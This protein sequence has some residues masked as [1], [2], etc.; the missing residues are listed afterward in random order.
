MIKNIATAITL[1]S[2][3]FSAFSLSFSDSKHL[4]ERTGFGVM[5][6]DEYEMVRGYSRN[7]AI[8]LLI[9]KSSDFSKSYS[10][11]IGWMDSK[12]LSYLFVEDEFKEGA[13]SYIECINLKSKL[14]L[15]YEIIN[16]SN[17]FLE[18]MTTFWHGHFVTSLDE[19]ND[20]DLKPKEM[21]KHLL[22]YRE[23]SLGNFRDFTLQM[24]SSWVMM[25][26]LG[27]SDNLVGANNNNFARELME[28]FTMGEA[29]GY[30]EK[31]I[32]ELAVALTGYRIDEDAYTKGFNWDY[33]DQRDIKFM[34]ETLSS[35]YSDDRNIKFEK[36]LDIILSKKSTHEFI[37]KKL[38]D[39]FIT[40]GQNKQVIHQ[41]ST[42]FGKDFKIKSV[43]EAILKSDEFWSDDNRKNMIKEPFDLTMGIFRLFGLKYNEL[44]FSGGEVV[45]YIETLRMSSPLRFEYYPKENLRSKSRSCEFNSPTE[46]STNQLISKIMSY[47]TQMNQKFYSPPSVSGWPNGDQWVNAQ[48]IYYKNELIRNLELYIDMDKLNSIDKEFLVQI[49]TTDT[50]YV[51]EGKDNLDIAKDLMSRNDFLLR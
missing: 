7:D 22:M 36:A 41:I 38:W 49:L 34:G 39:E 13:K 12:Y 45:E 48:Y 50:G 14:W 24:S 46:V 44:G 31:D 33:H 42:D 9:N 25:I 2:L 30:T 26:Y 47:S 17:P 19:I 28:L 16:N 20:G 18:K 8:N 29:G 32:W 35:E 43:V 21:L 51:Y 27:G 11:N 6:P 15:P 5:T 1:L 37:V 3:S 10:G 23:N 4:M 40:T